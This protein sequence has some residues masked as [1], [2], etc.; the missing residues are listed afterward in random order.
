MPRISRATSLLAEML[1][2]GP[3]IIGQ[4]RVTPSFLLSHGEDER[5][6]DLACFSNPHDALE[7]AKYDDQGV[8]RPL[9]TAPN[10]RHGWRLEL[11]SLDDAVLALNF[12]YPAALG[13]AAAAIG[14]HLHPIDLRET[15][16]RQSGMYAIV[17]KLTDVEAGKLIGLTCNRHTGCI[18]RILWSI[19]PGVPAIQPGIT[20]PGLSEIPIYC[21]E[22][23]NFLVARGRVA[24]K[25]ETS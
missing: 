2:N 6:A 22:A 9:K 16:A 15:L 25:G 20:E 8:Y 23:C 17:R 12:F 10:L 5:R 11:A 7:I 3:C 13:T 18:K 4:V 24:I 1:G 14:R 21:A 19:S